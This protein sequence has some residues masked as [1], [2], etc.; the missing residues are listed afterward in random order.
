[1][2][3]ARRHGLPTM[4]LRDRQQRTA[5]SHGLLTVVVRDRQQR[6]TPSELP[7]GCRC[8]HCNVD[9]QCLCEQTPFVWGL[10]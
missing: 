7:Q 4:L 2:P 1:M 3:A 5:P 9:R 10:M 8:L 6:I